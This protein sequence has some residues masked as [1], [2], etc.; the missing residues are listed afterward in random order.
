MKQNKLP[1]DDVRKY[2]LIIEGEGGNYSG[3]F[4]DL[5]GCTTGG[6]TLAEISR[7]AKEALLLYLEDFAA[8]GEA[9]PEASEA[10]RMELIEIR[11]NEVES[12]AK[13]PDAAAK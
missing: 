9:L 5:P 7:N 10:V 3:Y 1:S 11:R 8:R 2:P 6:R 4:P 13:N 12:F